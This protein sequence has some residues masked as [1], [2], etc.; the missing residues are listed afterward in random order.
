MQV[1]IKF[2]PKDFKGSG[3]LI[4]RNSSPLG[5]QDGASI[6]CVSY[7]IGYVS[8]NGSK[9]I[10]MVSIADGHIIGFENEKSLCDYLNN[11]DQ[12][13]RPMT[14]EEITLAFSSVGNRFDS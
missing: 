7:K 4:V 11:D 5:S 2:E 13:Y 1:S 10:F 8:E 3:Q 9:S 12:G 14:D 6:S